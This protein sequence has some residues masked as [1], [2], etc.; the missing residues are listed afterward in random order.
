MWHAVSIATFSTVFLGLAFAGNLTQTC[1]ENGVYKYCQSVM[2]EVPGV[3]NSSQPVTVLLPSE[4][5]TTVRQLLVLKSREAFSVEEAFFSYHIFNELLPAA[6]L[7]AR[8]GKVMT[9]NDTIANLNGSGQVVVSHPPPSGSSLC[10]NW[11]I[12]LFSGFGESTRIIKEDIPFDHGL[13][14]IVNR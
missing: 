5:L 7:R 14:H 12:T 1:G 3:T 13:I 9:S 11:P 4:S 2:N 8:F 10:N 6:T